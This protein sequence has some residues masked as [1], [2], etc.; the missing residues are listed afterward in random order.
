MIRGGGVPL[1]GRAAPRG[2]TF[3]VQYGT[4]IEIE[5]Y[6]ACGTSKLPTTTG[7][8]PAPAPS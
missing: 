2:L 5:D 3:G 6:G 8:R 4:C 7:R 1:V